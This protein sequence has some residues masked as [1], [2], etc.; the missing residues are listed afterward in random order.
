MFELR[1]PIDVFTSLRA[2]VTLRQDR[3]A[4]LA[5]ELVTLNEP[6]IVEQRVGLRLEYIFDNTLVRDLNLLNGT[7][8]KFY[9]EMVKRF[10][11][12]FLDQFNFDLGQGFMTI[13]GVD[14][15]HYQPLGRHIVLAVRAAAA[16]SF[17]S[18]KILYLLGGAD[19][20][21][22]PRFNDNI[23]MPGGDAFAFQTLA[24][25]IRGFD[26]NIRNGNSFALVN[27]ELRIPI[28]QMLF[29]RP[30]RSNFFRHL[31]LVGF[32]DAGTAWQG[33]SPYDK[34]NPLN[35]II[36]DNSPTI[37]VKVNYFR[38]PIVMGYGVGL[39]TMLFGYFIRV[40]YA[41][42]VDTRTFQTPKFHFSMGLDF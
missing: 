29:R 21:L 1:Y 35:T 3:F 15:R 31:Q 8:Y 33:S 27:T 22:F 17:G 26:F 2:A 38:D 19:N 42:G 24:P 39:R 18:E 32:V 11:I 34:D 40:D 41:R 30:L 6:P 28:L 12:Q 36:I 14:A 16:T 23:P 9:G 4:Y 7:R 5:S 37:V 13:L 25:N 10:Q 20:P